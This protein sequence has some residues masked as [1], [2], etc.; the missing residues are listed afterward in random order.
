MTA[1]LNDAPS[2]RRTM[3]ALV[4]RGAA[5]VALCAL[6]AGCASFGAEDMGVAWDTTTDRKAEPQGNGAWLSGDILVRSR[7]DAVR[8]YDAASGKRSWEYVPPGRSAVCHAAAD[9]AGS[10]LVLTRDGDGASASAKGKPCDTAVALDMKNG[11]EIWQVPLSTTGSGLQRLQPYAV[12]AGSGIAVLLKKDD[13]H[14]VDVR[15]GKTRWKAAL[16][17]DCVPG[18]TAVAERQVAA[19]L[20]CGGTD[21]PWGDKVPSDAELHAA[22]FDPAT[23][24]LLWSAPLGARRTVSWE[25]SADFVSADPV[26]VAASESGDS[27]FGAYYSF[28]RNGRPNPLIDFSGPYGEIQRSSR[29]TAA[30]DDN[31]LYVLPRH[32]QR[33]SRDVYRLTAFELATGDRV[34][35]G[36]LDDDRLDGDT[37]YRLLL[38]G[39]KLTVLT[40]RHRSSYHGFRVLDPAT[41]EQR[42]AR[43]L[44]DDPGPVDKFFEYKDRLIV[45][46]YEAYTTPPKPF[47]AYERL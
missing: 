1:R 33:N 36:T 40:S 6:T 11:R 16:P 21:N 12:S 28:G 22:A 32:R 31:R 25:A 20:A 39:G 3:R 15:T 26:V 43:S 8:G 34:W 30:V 13:L 29:L 5:L 4:T 47:T 37:G 10:V 14:A 18:R 19:L 44:P 2:G 41:G 27:D 38:Q 42:D 46:R 17:K 7:F 35:G 9:T 45:A 24:A 23:G